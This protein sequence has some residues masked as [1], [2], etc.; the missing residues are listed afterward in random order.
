[1]LVTV[2]CRAVLQ[3]LPLTSRSP[4]PKAHGKV[5]EERLRRRC[6]GHTSTPTEILLQKAQ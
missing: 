3:P 2:R 6:T 4:R 1:M 5:C